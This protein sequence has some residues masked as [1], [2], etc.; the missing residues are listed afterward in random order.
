MNDLDRT[1]PHSAWRTALLAACVAV[2][3]AA[4]GGG[5]SSDD[6]PEPEPPTGSTIPPAADPVAVPDAETSNGTVGDIH[7]ADGST[8]AALTCADI[9][10]QNNVVDS[11]HVH[12]AVH[13]SIF[14]DGTRLAVPV[15]IGDTDVGGTRCLYSVHTHS[16]N[17]MIHIE[18]GTPRTRTLGEFFAV[19]GQT[20]SSTDVA[21]LTGDPI[22]FYVRDDGGE[23]TEVDAADAADIELVDHREITIQVG[24]PPDEIPT[25]DW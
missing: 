12:E 25:F 17:G 24:T 3:F 6:D 10:G 9:N 23:I 22:R 21:G 13:L 2:A 14:L 15:E 19:W 20:L 7:W 11:P 5:G 16:R 4:C 8:G 1:R 18:A